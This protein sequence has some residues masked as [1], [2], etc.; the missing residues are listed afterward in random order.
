MRTVAVV[1]LGSRGLTV[2]ERLVAL[3]REPVRVEVVDPT[4]AG[5][6]VH[7]A[8]QPD[9]LLL[10]TT[11]GQVVLGSGPTLHEWVTERGL[12]IGADGCTVGTTGRSIVDTDF[13]PRRV[14][15]EYLTWVRDEVLRTAPSHVDVRL[16]RT[17]AVDLSPELVLTLADG[18]RL[19]ADHVVLT[20]GYAGAPPGPYPLPA[21]V[22]HVPA[23]AP[24]GI[25]GF[26]LT[27]MDVMS[28]LTVGRGG[29]YEGD[30]AGLRY[31]PSGR[32]PEL[33]FF[34]R[35]GLP[36]R[37]RPRTMRLGPPY[38]PLVFTPAAVDAL[39][40]A[41]GPLDFAAD[42]EPLLRTEIAVAYRR[43][44]ARLA[45]TD[46]EADLRAD[47]AGTLARLDR[48]DPF[49]P[50]A[51]W[52]PAAGM[53]LDSAEAYQK[54]LAGVVQADLAEGLLG[55]AGSPVKA[56]LDVLRALR[57]TFRHAVDY[58][59]LTP[60]SL[61]DFLDRAV[62]AVN[63]AVVGPQW[64]RHAELLALL[65]A[66]VAR[67]PFGPAP[68]VTGTRVAS[69]RLAEPCAVDVTAVVDAR[70]PLPGVV[71][72]ASPLV[73]ALHARG[74]L[75]PYGPGVPGADVDADQHPVGADGTADPRISLL[76]PLH[77]GATFYTNLVPSPGPYSRP[78]WDAER[79]ARAALG[80]GA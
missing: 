19:A 29:S 47:L 48:A 36:C 52:D 20:T 66:G 54:W 70:V 18:R 7:A 80:P 71:G 13:L 44:Q 69:T 22:D 75:R 78:L 12:R 23:G 27:A 40:A 62:P 45:G 5:S 50:A 72:S 17:S 51:A 21:A 30:G 63:R 46:L 49:D 39:R 65:D 68:R 33:L 11:A 3:A 57:D 16:H 37:A 73:R 15:G 43:A 60:G 79:I 38:E 59:G 28:A 10:N 6:G 67:T 58:G 77:E 56:G 41:R 24:V 55:F 53:A 14:L 61:A 32:E 8:G 9:Y 34:S 2:L 35:T 31:R 42:V 76:G 1:G 74:V 4:C 25:G 64:E 26:G